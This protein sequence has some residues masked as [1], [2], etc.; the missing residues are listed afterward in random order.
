MRHSKPPFYHRSWSFPG[1]AIVLLL[2]LVASGCG[3]EGFIDQPGAHTDSLSQ[4]QF[5]VQYHTWWRTGACPTT[6]PRSTWSHWA[7]MA[8]H[9]PCHQPFTNAPWLR[10]TSSAGYPLI[11]PYSGQNGEVFRWHVRLAKASRID[12]FFVSIFATDAWTWAG[13]ETALKVAYEENFKIGIEGWQPHESGSPT[14]QEWMNDVLKQIAAFAEDS[15]Y[16]S[17]FLRINGKPAYW[18]NYCRNWYGAIEN[19]QTFLDTHQVF[20]ILNCG[21]QSN[22]TLLGLNRSMTQSEVQ[23]GVSY[24]AVYTTENETG[25]WW[26]NPNFSSDLA[27]KKSAGLSAITHGLPGFDERLIANGADRIGRYAPREKG[28]VLKNYLSSAVSNGAAIALLESFNDWVEYTQ[29][30]PGYDVVAYRN[31][32]QEKIYDNDPYRYLR[33][34]AHAKGVSWNSLEPPPCEIV[35]VLLRENGR[36]ACASNAPADV[37]PQDTSVPPECTSESN[38]TFCSRLG[39]NCGS[40]SGTDNCGAA[41]TATCGTCTSPQTCGGGGTAN[42]CGSPACTSESNATFCTRLAKN[43]GSVTGTDNCG[44]SRTAGCGSCV[45]PKTCGGGGTANVCGAAPTTPTYKLLAGERLAAG[46]FRKSADG[47]FKF[48]YQGDGNLV[49]YQGSTS[50][51]SSETGGT[52]P[53]K[54]AMQGDGNLVVYNASS[55]AVWASHTAGNPGAY[56]VVQNDGNVVI[57]SSGASPLWSTG[58]CCH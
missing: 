22:E 39:K 17:A 41:R 2:A 55:Q 56:L 18:F 44:N 4:T 47:R 23:Q 14:P 1:S 57:Y 50:L 15:P 35:D 24:N 5:Y 19:L 3:E 54:T 13:F 6:N 53:G 8:S 20:W 31:V 25:K 11:G 58:T 29:I 34:F 43:C 16:A 51:W 27:S 46:E 42:V 40:V 32:G 38:A 9:N 45:S 12:G 26:Y 49:L 30:E 52:S 7:W 36:T 21:G 48:I 37:D 28:D 10:E 33:T